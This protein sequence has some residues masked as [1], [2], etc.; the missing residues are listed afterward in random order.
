[1]RLRLPIESSQE[2]DHASLREKIESDE[3]SYFDE[4]GVDCGRGRKWGDI[5]MVA[6][7]GV[8][9]ADRTFWC[10]LTIYIRFNQGDIDQGIDELYS[11]RQPGGHCLHISITRVSVITPT[12]RDDSEHLPPSSASLTMT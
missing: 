1:M 3:M 2:T 11:I 10:Q 5:I 4:A 6:R 7:I 12:M 8:I 9:M